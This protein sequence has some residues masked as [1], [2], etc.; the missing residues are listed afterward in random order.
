MKKL[1]LKSWKVAELDGY[2]QYGRRGPNW[3]R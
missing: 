3:G 1:F 2:D